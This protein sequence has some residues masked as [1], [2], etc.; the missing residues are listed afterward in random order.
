MWEIEEG[1]TLR[2]RCH[3][4]H[5]FSV[6]LVNIALEQSVSCAL[7]VALRSFEE[8]AEIARNLESQAEHTS[9]PSSAKM[10][11]ERIRD[12]DAE[13]TIVRDAIKR[14][15]RLIKLVPSAGE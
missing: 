3:V 6:D 1:D 7:A 10:W 8:R 15:N 5:A 9:R 4:G 2:Y 11:R 13:A 12:L 14:I